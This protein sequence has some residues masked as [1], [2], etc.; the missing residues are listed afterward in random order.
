[1]A[2]ERPTSQ[3]QY[4]RTRP[5]LAVGEDSPQSVVITLQIPP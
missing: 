5:I 2:G 4:G 3:D 1:M